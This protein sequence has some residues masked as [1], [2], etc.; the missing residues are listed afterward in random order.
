M[1]CRQ[2][3]GLNGGAKNENRLARCCICSCSSVLLPVV[4]RRPVRCG[5]SLKICQKGGILLSNGILS[6]FV[7]NT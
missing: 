5:C 7:V 4:V 2:K 3:A 1:L 6:G